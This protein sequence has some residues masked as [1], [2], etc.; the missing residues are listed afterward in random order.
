MI[1]GA[2]MGSAALL[3]AMVASRASA[4]ADHA[5]RGEVTT[6]AVIAHAGKALG[7]GL[8]QL[9]SVLAHEGV[10]SSLWYEVPKSR[11]AT[12]RVREAV[13]LGADLLFVWGG[14]GMVRRC[15]DGLTGGRD[16]DIAIVPAGTANLLA[17][18][19]GVPRTSRQRWRSGYAVNGA[20][21]M[22]AW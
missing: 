20:A 16:V 15:V 1:A 4:L 13:D 6:V 2:L 5:P 14:D 19:L 7:G 11:K 9:R 3:V 21:S 17:T 8:D 12:K 18:N 10:D 22:W